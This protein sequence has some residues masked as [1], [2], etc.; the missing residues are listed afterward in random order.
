MIGWM[1][2]GFVLGVVVTLGAVLV[3]MEHDAGEWGKGIPGWRNFE[4]TGD[5][6]VYDQDEEID[7]PLVRLR[8]P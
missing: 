4:R 8:K 1:L 7:L 3:W 5:P 2:V 6:Y